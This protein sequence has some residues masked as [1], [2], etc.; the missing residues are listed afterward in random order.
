MTKL[1]ITNCTSHYA[2]CITHYALILLLSL[3][4]PVSAAKKK[5]AKQDLFPNGE[6]ITEW[7]NDT[8]RVDVNSLGKKYI[9]T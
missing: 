9:I 5:V 7:F 2:L 4:L 6:P 1:P 8:T 3:S